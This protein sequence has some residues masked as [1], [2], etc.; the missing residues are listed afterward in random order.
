MSNKVVID[1]LRILK[2]K[3]AP[4]KLYALEGLRCLT[5]EELANIVGPWCTKNMVDGWIRRHALPC[6]KAGK[7]LVVTVEDFKQWLKDNRIK[8]FKI[9]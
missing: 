9:A 6:S 5:K 7:K 3:G 8:I 2:A 4:S 1:D